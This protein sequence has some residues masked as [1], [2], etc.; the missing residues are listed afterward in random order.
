[1]NWN[2]LLENPIS[3]LSEPLKLRLTP[4]IK[5]WSAWRSMKSKNVSIAPVYEGDTLIGFITE[6]CVEVVTSLA[7]MANLDVYEV[8]QKEYLK[9]N[10]NDSIKSALIAAGQHK[11]SYIHVVGSNGEPMGVINVPTAFYKLD[12]INRQRMADGI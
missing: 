6:Q 5:L 11:V 8:V 3:M 10:H 1:M 4:E 9:V 2:E 7:G 12:Q